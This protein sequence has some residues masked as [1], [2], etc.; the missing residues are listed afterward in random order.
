MPKLN[1]D[2]K[3]EK[4]L[5]SGASITTTGNGK[6]SES[7]SY[8]TNFSP[9]NLKSLVLSPEGLILTFH[10]TSSN[11]NKLVRRLNF[12]DTLDTYTY[13]D[14]EK[15]IL[16]FLVGKRVYSSVEEIV[17]IAQSGYE[18]KFKMPKRQLGVVQNKLIHKLK[19]LRDVIVISSIPNSLEEFQE[20]YEEALKRDNVV[21]ADDKE[22]VAQQG[23][24]VIPINKKW[25][26]AISLRPAYYKIDEKGGV[27]STKFQSAKEKFSKDDEPEDI[28]EEKSTED[29]TNKELTTKDK[30]YLEEIDNLFNLYH[31]LSTDTQTLQSNIEELFN[32]ISDTPLR[33]TEPIKLYLSQIYEFKPFSIPYFIDEELVAD[34]QELQVFNEFLM[35]RG[36]RTTKISSGHFKD[37][38]DYLRKS[39]IEHLKSIYY[40]NRVKSK[41]KMNHMINVELNLAFV[42]AYKRPEYSDLHQVLK[43]ETKPLTDSATEQLRNILQFPMSKLLS[44]STTIPYI[45][46]W[47]KNPVQVVIEKTTALDDP[48]YTM[49]ATL[50]SISRWFTYSKSDTTSQGYIELVHD[51]LNKT[52]NLDKGYFSRA[53]TQIDNSKSKSIPFEPDKIWSKLEKMVLD[54]DIEID[55]EDK[56]SLTLEDNSDVIDTT[57]SDYPTSDSRVKDSL[58]DDLDTLILDQEESTLLDEEKLQEDYEKDEQQIEEQLE[59]DIDKEAETKEL[60]W[61]PNKDVKLYI[62][63]LNK[64]PLA[65]D[66]WYNSAL[67]NS[68]ENIIQFVQEA[69]AFLEDLEPDELDKETQE[70]LIDLQM[71]YL[72]RDDSR[73]LKLYLNM[74]KTYF[75]RLKTV[76]KLN[77]NSYTLENGFEHYYTLG[78]TSVTPSNTHEYVK[79]LY[80]LIR[81][82]IK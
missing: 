81:G 69:N 6:D 64:V 63:W 10:T 1:L 14:E 53:L 40:A 16:S 54:S 55:E 25:Y 46:S 30:E 58:L 62:T 23:V 47:S 29:T 50:L 74:K 51:Y 44:S 31:T 67:Q 42:R 70:Y 43:L 7:S 24:S 9:N 71:S 41:S 68:K 4:L 77:S 3:I 60:S 45:G 12:P 20:Y 61:K 66:N 57:V 13:L 19:R 5:Y 36:T 26:N 34:N 80:Y 38:R 65:F 11:Q 28:T 39:F 2:A 73:Q 75:N 78:G 8:S 72:S 48:V 27:L 18:P 79:S 59:E 82:R 52:Y 35:S 15:E 49:T 76:G 22:L 21:L 56:S 32:N 17:I 37:L 33:G